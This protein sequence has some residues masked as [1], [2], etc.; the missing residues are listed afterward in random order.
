MFTRDRVGSLLLARQV[1]FDMAL[2][3][4]RKRNSGNDSDSL[5]PSATCD[6]VPFV[7][8]YLCL[9]EPKSLEDKSEP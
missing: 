1:S 3:T 6:G 4:T 7:I 9:S 2:S 5:K 8:N